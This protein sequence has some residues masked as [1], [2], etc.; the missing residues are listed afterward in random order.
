MNSFIKLSCSRIFK[1]KIFDDE[2]IVGVG[3]EEAEERT[4]LSS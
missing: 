3:V 4:N 2:Q 1:Q